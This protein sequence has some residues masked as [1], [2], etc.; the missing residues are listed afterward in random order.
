[1]VRRPSL[2]GTAARQS[3]RLARPGWWRRRPF[4]PVPDPGYLRFRMQTAYG[5][6]GQQPPIAADL[7]A[8]LR[9]CREYPRATGGLARR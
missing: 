5:D 7:V 4:L 1:M 9:W 6:T 3:L 2:W 8:Y